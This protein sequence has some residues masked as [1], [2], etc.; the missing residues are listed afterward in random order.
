MVCVSEMAAHV[1]DLISCTHRATSAL[2]RSRW[3]A[4]SLLAVLWESIRKVV[5]Q[6]NP[7]QTTSGAVELIPKALGLQ[8]SGGFAME[9]PT[10]WHRQLNGT[11]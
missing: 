10:A 1:P 2:Q 8:R 7:S 5:A 3:A 11:A 4:S 9:P 6:A